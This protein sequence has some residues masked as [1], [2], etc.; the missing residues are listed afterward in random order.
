MAEIL[1]PS[2]YGTRE[3]PIDQLMALHMPV[4]AVEPEFRRRIE[5]WVVSKRGAVGFGDVLPRSRNNGVSRA[6]ASNRSFHQLQTFRDGSR[7]ACAIDVVVRRGGGL[8]H[9]SWAVPWALVPRQGSAEATRWGV[10]ANI[11]NESWHL[12]PVEIDGFWRW[13]LALR[14]RPRVG[15]PLPVVS[16]PVVTR[17]PKAPK[18]PARP[19]TVK[20]SKGIT[21]NGNTVNMP[22]IR[23]GSKGRHVH[24]W[25]RII[26]VTADGD[27]GPVTDRSTR[28]AQKMLGVHVDG[29]VGPITW[30][31]ALK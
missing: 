25:Q 20:P 6:S 31:A 1:Y 30:V 16:P 10:H 15:Y 2:G 14:P 23:R 11:G 9:S 18:P 8:G 28:V 26:S 12:Q 21:V 22:T 5:A 7:W 27:F 24:L 3:L 4:W 17:P 19:S 29:I 13:T